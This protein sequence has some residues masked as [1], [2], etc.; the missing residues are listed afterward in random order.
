MPAA[1]SSEPP[2]CST[3]HTA[4]VRSIEQTNPVAPS[5]DH[6]LWNR[7]LRHPPPALRRHGFNHDE[8]N[9]LRPVDG[10][11]HPKPY[12]EK[13]IFFMVADLADGRRSIE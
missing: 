13:F 12:Q 9:R 10:K 7:T 11:D 6:S 5:S 2:I 3:A 8:G 4:Q 1:P